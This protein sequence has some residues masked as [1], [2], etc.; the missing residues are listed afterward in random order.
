[1]R[2]GAAAQGRSGDVLVTVTSTL[3]LRVTSAG[4]VESAQFSP[5]LLPDV[6]TCAAEAIYKTKLDETG[7]VSIPIEFSY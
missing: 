5:P 2:A 4:V 6:Q 7:L 3:R 1:V